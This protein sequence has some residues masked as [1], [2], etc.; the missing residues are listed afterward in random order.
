MYHVYTYA[1]IRSRPICSGHGG[2]VFRR[3]QILCKSV[4][5]QK[6]IKSFYTCKGTRKTFGT[7]FIG[8][9]V[10]LNSYNKFG[11]YSV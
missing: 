1:K 2:G 5:E 6:K 3:R 7:Y 8:T 11:A 9:T 10:L 4:R